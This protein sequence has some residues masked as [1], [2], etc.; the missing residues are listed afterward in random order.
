VHLNSE[1]VAVVCERPKKHTIIIDRHDRNEIFAQSW[2]Q[3][4]VLPNGQIYAIQDMQDSTVFTLF[5]E[6]MKEKL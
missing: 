4:R 1:L 3:I 5:D 2:Q 6:N